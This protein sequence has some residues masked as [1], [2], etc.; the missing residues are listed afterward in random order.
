MG[1]VKFYSRNFPFPE[2]QQPPCLALPFIGARRTSL[3]CW[4]V[5][6]HHLLLYQVKGLARRANCGKLSLGRWYQASSEREEWLLAGR[7]GNNPS[8]RDNPQPSPYGSLGA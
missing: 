4:L 3:L 2:N 5:T 6:L 1:N 8:N 7:Y